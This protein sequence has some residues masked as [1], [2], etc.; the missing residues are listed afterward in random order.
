MEELGAYAEQWYIDNICPFIRAA[1]LDVVSI[2]GMAMLRRPDSVNTLPAWEKLTSSVS[3]GPDYALEVSSTPGDALLGQ[4]LCQIFFIDRV[5]LR[6]NSLALMVAKEYQSIGDALILLATEDQ[7]NCCAALNTL[8]TILKLNLSSDLTIPLDLVLAHVHRVILHAT[9][10]EVISTAQAVLA[11]SL[12]DDTL[13]ARFF[14]LVTADHALLTLAKLESQCL[15]SPPSNTQSALHL[16]GPFLDFAYTSF[17]SH[18]QTVLGAIARYIRFVRTAIA[19]S[20]TFDTRFAAAQSLNALPSI[21]RA[22][23][24]AKPTRPIVLALALTLPT[25]LADDD[26]DIR[27]LAA[28]ATATLLRAAPVVPVLAAH[29]LARHLRA[30]FATSPLLRREAAR[31]LTR[32]E[33]P[34][35]RTL[36]LA[37]KEDAALFATEKQNL[38]LDAALDAVFWSRVLRAS[39]RHARFAALTA[40]TLDALATLTETA[41]SEVDGALGWAAKPD[42]FALGVRVICAAEVVV[43]DAG[44]LVALRRFADACAEKEGHGLWLERVE[45]VLQKSVVRIVGRVRGSLEDVLRKIDA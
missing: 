35:A 12:S 19:S 29:A 26:D 11:S 43:E 31:R 33:L 42:V 10:A 4:S 41:R 32:P 40:W 16:L 15:N 36:A 18:R 44:V 37:R 20:N 45:R 24:T 34:F 2:C 38:Y 28:A 39:H 25:L 22:D 13:R 23:A 1:F 6:D 21:W 7:D 17:P 8:D 9:D 27:A 3:I 14:S 30:T 5:I